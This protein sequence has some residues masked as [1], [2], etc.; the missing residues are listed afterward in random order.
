MG[1]INK[2]TSRMTELHK[3]A[4]VTPEQVDEDLRMRGLDRA[5]EIESLRRL[6]RVMAAKFAPQARQELMQNSP[7][8]KQFPMFEEAVAAGSPEWATTAATHTEASIN[9]IVGHSDPETTI[10]VPVSGWSMRD[11]GINDGDLVLVDT[12]REA[13]DGEIVVAFIEGEGQVVKR[14]R[15]KKGQPVVLE[16]ANP[17]FPPRV[18]DESQ[19]LRIHGVVIGRVG[20]IKRS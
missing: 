1:D 5:T 6:G 3:I 20:R 15:T 13:V 7:M 18:I 10:W 17:D 19:T 16:S 4:G 2:T 12:R 8:A 14:L 11:E 9:D